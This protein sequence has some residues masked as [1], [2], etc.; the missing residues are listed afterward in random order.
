MYNEINREAPGPRFTLIIASGCGVLVLIT[1]L[2]LLGLI[3]LRIAV[4]EN[5]VDWWRNWFGD[6][7]FH[8][9]VRMVFLAKGSPIWALT[10]CAFG[11]W[12]F[13][14][15]LQIITVNLLKATVF[16]SQ[17]ITPQAAEMEKIYGELRKIYSDDLERIALYERQL[18][19]N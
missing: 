14:R 10:L 17:V 7:I 15:A 12:C 1:I 18:L 9:I 5:M 2:S 6:P 11:V 19:G 3:L 16:S 4:G 8:L 13:E